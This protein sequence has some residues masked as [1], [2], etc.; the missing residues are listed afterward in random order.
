MTISYL[1]AYLLLSVVTCKHWILKC[2][3]FFYLLSLTYHQ[4]CCPQ[5]N[6]LGKDPVATAM[7]WQD[8]SNQSLEM[9]PPRTVDACGICGG[10]NSTCTD[11]AGVLNGGKLMIAI[12]L[13]YVHLIMKNKK[14][15]KSKQL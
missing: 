1:T 6:G 13:L 7:T 4:L 2:T 11:C 5:Q 9:L 12:S 10:N 3:S 14:K 8:C 15:I